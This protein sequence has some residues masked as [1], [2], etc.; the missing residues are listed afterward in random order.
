MTGVPTWLCGRLNMSDKPIPIS[1]KKIMMMT[2]PLYL[3]A[4]GR[5]RP[6]TSPREAAF[7]FKDIQIKE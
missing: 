1:L 6:A 5:D 3:F 2:L 4:L 7:S